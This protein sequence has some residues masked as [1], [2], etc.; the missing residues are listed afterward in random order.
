MIQLL[1]N[2]TSPPFQLFLITQ[3]LGGAFTVSEKSSNIFIFFNLY[4]ISFFQQ[5]EIKLY[6]VNDHYF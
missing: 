1:L 5:V 2:K 6:L 3:S 4:H